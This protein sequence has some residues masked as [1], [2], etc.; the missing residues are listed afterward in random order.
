MSE[1]SSHTHSSGATTNNNALVEQIE[2]S[3]E[4][5]LDMSQTGVERSTTEEPTTQ[6]TGGGDQNYNAQG[7][8]NRGRR[9]AG[10]E[11]RAQTRRT[12]G[13]EPRA[14]NRKR[15]R[16]RPAWRVGATAE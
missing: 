4:T 12:V 11:P 16:G 9:T 10:A 6:V 7:A 15:E 8:Q 13:A 1:Q 2:S 3:G 14:Q 5:D